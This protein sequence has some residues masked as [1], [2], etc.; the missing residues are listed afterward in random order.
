MFLCKSIKLFFSFFS[1]GEEI[2]REVNFGI[3]NHYTNPLGYIWIFGTET[4]IFFILNLPGY[5]ICVCK[6]IF[7]FTE[8]N[9]FTS[10]YMVSHIRK[11]QYYMDDYSIF[12]LK[13]FVWK[14]HQRVVQKMKKKPECRKL[15]MNKQIVINIVKM[16]VTGIHCCP[17]GFWNTINTT[18]V[19]RNKAYQ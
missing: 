8:L 7:I 17:F 9:W 18:E 11:F 5:R 19:K 4:V 2:K 1:S 10:N 14:I 6:H 16:C 13:R 12:L 15:H 3:S